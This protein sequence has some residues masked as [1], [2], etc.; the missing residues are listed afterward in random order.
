MASNDDLIAA[1]AQSPLQT[2]DA[3]RALAA[4]VGAV[5]TGP[6]AGPAVGMT[7]LQT[8]L[9]EHYRRRH[10]AKVETLLEKYR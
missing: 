3:I 4:M 10:D 6:G 2:N 1:L 9:N 8:V 7:A 5:T